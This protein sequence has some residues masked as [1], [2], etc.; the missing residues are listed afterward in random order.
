MYLE[1]F[2]VFKNLALLTGHFRNPSILSVASL[3]SRVKMEAVILYSGFF[4]EFFT[5]LLIC[6]DKFDAFFI[7][8]RK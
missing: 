1:Q 8:P 4:P 3:C 5:V 2:L 7:S 6:F